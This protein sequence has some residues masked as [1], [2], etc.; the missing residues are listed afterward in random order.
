MKPGNFR[1][2]RHLTNAIVMAINSGLD[3]EGL[4][5]ET[6]AYV[7]TPKDRNT[8][9]ANLVRVV[10]N[11]NLPLTNDHSKF[12]SALIGELQRK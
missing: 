6:W 7:V 9:I 8:L 3:N 4:W 1:V 2:E 5:V 10:N 12:S 11:N